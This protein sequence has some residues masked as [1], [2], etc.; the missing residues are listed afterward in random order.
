[1]AHDLTGKVGEFL[2]RHLIFPLLEFLSERQIYDERSLLEGKLKLLRETN[3]VDFALDVHHVLQGEE[4]D[5]GAKELASK[6]GVVVSRLKE[7]QENTEPIVKV[8]ENE[9]VLAKIQTARVDGRQLF[10]YLET[11]HGFRAEMLDTLYDYAKFQYECG[12]YSGAAE[13][14]YFHRVLTPSDDK[15]TINTLWGKLASEILMQNW[16]VA[17]DDM[18]RLKEVVDASSASPL[19]LLQ[20]RAWLIH[21][22][23]FVFFNLAPAKG[24]ESLIELFLYSQ[25]YL[26]AIQTMCPHVLRYLTTAVVV[27]ATGRKRTLVKDLVKVIQRESYAYQDPITEF[28]ECLYVNFDFDGAQQKLRECEEVLLNDFFLVA[29]HDDF[30]ENARLMIFETFCQIHRC[31]RI[32]MLAEKLNMTPEE[33]EK[34]IVNMI[35]NSPLD[36][37]IDSKLGHVVMNSPVQS[38]YQQVIEKTKGLVFR[39]QLLSNNI[40]KRAEIKKAGGHEWAPAAWTQV[41]HQTKS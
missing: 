10:E 27:H 28:V 35:R 11:Q 19:Q 25:P 41:E 12:N 16:D 15:N 7:L 29:C 23:L 22:S 6:R 24:R 8:F 39:S 40:D 20:Q 5:E 31:I 30:I 4:E 38:V 21:W 17:Y 13:Y 32:S 33:A 9:D 26:N 14:L 18:M 37:K 1:M 2:D 34:W 3:M 36:A